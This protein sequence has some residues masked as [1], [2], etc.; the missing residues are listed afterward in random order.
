MN[1]DTLRAA[2]ATGFWFISGILV[3]LALA[4]TYCG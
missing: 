4:V 2:V 3:G 1:D